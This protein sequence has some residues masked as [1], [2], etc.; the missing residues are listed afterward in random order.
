MC[1]LSKSCSKSLIF[2]LSSPPNATL[3]DITPLTLGFD[4]EVLSYEVIL[5]FSI[6][7]V[8]SSSLIFTSYFSLRLAVSSSSCISA[9][10]SSR[11]VTLSLKRSFSSSRNSF[12]DLRISMFCDV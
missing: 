2:F 8:Y 5:S 4:I 6:L 7:T 12:S 3:L 10:S 9:I 1:L 11:A